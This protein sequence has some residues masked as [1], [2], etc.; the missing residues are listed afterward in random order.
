MADTK[1]ILQVD[2]LD[3]KLISVD[4]E[5]AVN[6]TFD[7]VFEGLS[8][9]EVVSTAK[10]EL[11]TLSR[12]ELVWVLEER[13]GRIEEGA[14]GILDCKINTQNALD[15]TRITSAKTIL[16]LVL[17][18]DYGNRTV[19]GTAQMRLHPGYGE[20]GEPLVE[21]ERSVEKHNVDPEAH[22]ELF[23]SLRDEDTRILQEVD[24]KIADSKNAEVEARNQAISDAVNQAKDEMASSYKGDLT[25]FAVAAATSARA[26]ASSANAAAIAADK[27]IEKLGEA[28]EVV[29]TLNGK[30]SQVD[31]KVEVAGRY[32]DS[33][34]GAAGQAN[35]SAERAVGAEENIGV[36]VTQVRGLAAGIKQDADR[37]ASVV[38]AVNDAKTAVETAKRQ[39]EGLAEEVGGYKQAASG[40]ASAASQSASN[41]EGSAN[42]AKGHADRAE[43]AAE[44]AGNYV[45]I[46]LPN[47]VEIL[48]QSIDDKMSA[49][50]AHL[51]SAQTAIIRNIDGKANE[52]STALDGKIESANTALDSKVTEAND[53]KDNAVKARGEAEGFKGDAEKS[54]KSAS[55]SAEQASKSAQQAEDAKEAIGDVGGRLEAVETSVEGKKPYFSKYLTDKFDVLRGDFKMGRIDIL[56]QLHEGFLMRDFYSQA[57]DRL[58]IPA[59]NE[60]I[61]V[62]SVGTVRLSVIEDTQTTIY[63]YSGST[64]YKTTVSGSGVDLTFVRETI[65]AMPTAVEA[66]SGVV[67]Y[68]TAN[69]YVVCTGGHILSADLKTEVATFYA[70]TSSEFILKKGESFYFYDGAVKK[71]ATLT[72]AED[73]TPTITYGGYVQTDGKFYPITPTCYVKQNGYGLYLGTTTEG[74]GYLY[75]ESSSKKRLF[76]V[77]LLKIGTYNLSPLL[78]FMGE[79]VA[80]LATESNG[81]SEIAMPVAVGLFDDVSVTGNL[82]GLFAKDFKGD[83]LYAYTSQYFYPQIYNLFRIK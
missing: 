82:K 47:K 45:N 75:R 63:S 26:S 25:D 58:L 11:H 21:I 36:Y 8:E 42:T 37:A 15:I 73:G 66:L 12:K 69:G 31:G 7:I 80:L 19:Y 41:A 61:Q 68:K 44:R 20:G 35:R 32:A 14:L 50:D 9:T 65:T 6:E 24:G 30:I 71:L 18:D 55:E 53:A 74:I 39:V 40:S 81:A 17:T 28:Y 52:V 56:S 62:D 33:A 83:I 51:E 54:A 29:K 48:D 79:A 70:V 78:F 64:L 23:Q 77:S 46:E 72:L 67:G 34:V 49:V 76:G 13:I 22:K 57:K 1:L 10:I 59:K 5:V 4:S 27:T 60:I 38:G 2:N 43:G 16:T 3:H